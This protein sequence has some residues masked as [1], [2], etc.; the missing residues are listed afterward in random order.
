MS[1]ADR[2]GGETAKERVTKTEQWAQRSRFCCPTHCWGERAST[3]RPRTDPLHGWRHNHVLP[4]DLCS[5]LNQHLVFSC[6]I[7]KRGVPKPLLPGRRESREELTGRQSPASPARTKAP[8]RRQAPGSGSGRLPAR[9][10][11]PSLRP[12]LP[13]LTVA[14][15]SQGREH[16]PLELSRFKDGNSAP[17]TI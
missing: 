16:A 1:L 5:F 4:L 14:A 10:R 15:T 9:Q 8:K 17:E 13:C 3:P 11:T 12:S 2:Q 6:F 7:P